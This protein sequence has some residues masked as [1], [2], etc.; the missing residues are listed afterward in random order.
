MRGLNSGGRSNFVQENEK[1]LELL[2]FNIDFCV[3][4]LTWSRHQDTVHITCPAPA[5]NI[6]GEIVFCCL[7][8]RWRERKR[9]IYVDFLRKAGVQNQK[10]PH[11]C[12]G[13]LIFMVRGSISSQRIFW[14]LSNYDKDFEDHL[15]L[16]NM[17]NFVVLR[18]IINQW[19]G[20]CLSIYGERIIKYLKRL[21]LNSPFLIKFTI[22][23]LICIWNDFK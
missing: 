11:V 2:K 1:V 17:W 6:V 19:N 5:I 21:N 14:S 10:S 15:L 18:K 16:E 9:R 7:C 3:D 8:V 12:Y 20:N 22:Y 13:T 4:F 23:L